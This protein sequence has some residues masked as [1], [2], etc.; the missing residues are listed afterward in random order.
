[1][2][3]RASA[4]DAAG[5]QDAPAYTIGYGN[6]TFEAF[7]SL[8]TNYGIKF[9][10]DV[11]SS[12]YSRYQPDFNRDTLPTLLR[13][14]GLKYA[15]FGQAL[16]GRPSDPSCYVDG[17][18][19]YDACRRTMAFRRGVERIG[20]AVRSGNVVVIMCSE[21]RAEDCHR[22]KMIG[23][24]LSESG[25]RVEHIDEHGHLTNQQEVMARLSANQVDLF[26]GKPATGLRSR[27]A[28]QMTDP[29]AEDTP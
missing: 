8:L 15:Y 2:Y 25:V 26:S 20:D 19:D 23:V 9:V 22:S 3:D 27:R 1:M 10:L 29:N 4:T 17:V 12:P 11:R 13:P 14:Y 28:Y 24:D 16:G 18:V 7:V 21:L 5:S 6:R